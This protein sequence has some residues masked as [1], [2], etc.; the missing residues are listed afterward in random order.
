MITVAAGD[1][2]QYTVYKIAQSPPR[3]RVSR[4]LTIKVT[5]TPRCQ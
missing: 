5:G 3:D 2:I 1:D 4:G